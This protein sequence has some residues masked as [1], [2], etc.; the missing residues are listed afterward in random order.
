M[1]SIFLFILAFNLLAPSSYANGLT[2]QQ[3]KKIADTASS[4]GLGK[5][6]ALSIAV[7]NEEGNL[8]YFQRADGAYSGS[9]EASIAKAKS[10]NAFR[11]PTSAFVQGLKDGRSGLLS[12]PGIV[13]LEG[14]VPIEIAGKHTG[15][16]GVSGAKS[17]EDEEA[18]NISLKALRKP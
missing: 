2:L 10:A 11:R 3:A 12:V 1:K 14:G 6:W 18:A 7:V 9:I 4:Y 5:G 16:I 15:A 13:A 8:I 17:T